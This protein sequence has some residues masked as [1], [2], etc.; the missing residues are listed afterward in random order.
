[1][2]RVSPISGKNIFQ[3]DLQ[4]IAHQLDKNP[5]VRHV[6]VERIL[7]NQM[8]IHIEERKPYARIQLGKIFLMIQIDLEAFVLQ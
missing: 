2:K 5:W 6:S 8:R 1:M 7:P 4:T 3:L